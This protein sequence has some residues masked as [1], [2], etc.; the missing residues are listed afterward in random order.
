VDY[1]SNDC[2]P[3]NYAA[4][5]ED[6]QRAGYAVLIIDS[7]SH[8]WAGR[9]GALEMVDDA[10]RRSKSGNTYVAWRDV[11]PAHN[12]MI[13]AILG[14]QMHVIATMR[15]KTEYVMEQDSRGKSSPRKIGMAP[16]QRDGM[17]YEFDVVAEM[18]LDNNFIVTKTRC[19]ALNAKC[20][21]R[22][23]DDSEPVR[24]LRAWLDSGEAVTPVLTATASQIDEALAKRVLLDEIK[25]IKIALAWGDPE[26]KAFATNVIGKPAS[27]ADAPELQVLLESMR[28]ILLESERERMAKQEA[29]FVPCEPNVTEATEP[30][31]ATE[32]DGDDLPF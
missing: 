28:L 10:A 23:S 13:D 24:L 29:D 8:A 6:A 22:P 21:N 7:L 20:Y 25:E 5:I 3:L 9:G 27:K 16:I 2:S 30:E 19:A 14:A 1:L 31:T 11:T 17:D 15:A 26:T 4:K 18:D 32:P 12:R